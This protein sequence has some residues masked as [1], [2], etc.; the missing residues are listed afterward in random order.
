MILLAPIFVLAALYG[1]LVLRAKPIGNHP[2]FRYDRPLVIAHRGGAGLWPENTLHAFTQAAALGV[3]VLEID[4][5]STRDGQLVVI[6][7]DT[8]ERTAHGTGR[9][10]DLS[11]AELQQLDAGYSWSADQGKTF[12]LRGRGIRIPT[13]AEV[14]S[15]LPH[16]AMII[17]IKAHQPAMVAELG[18]MIRHYHMTSRVL[19]ASF[20]VEI[21]REF[22]RLYPEIATSGASQEVRR[23]YT[24]HL[25]RLSRVYS[26]PMESLDVPEYSDG[27]HIAT[28]RFVNAAHERNLHVHVWTINE[29][30]AMQRLLDYG[31]DGI[32]TDYPD[33]LLR[34]LDSD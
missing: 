2:F 19:V 10:R 28:R 32:T 24:L 33:R 3:D 27:R 31:V 23:F 1:V 34:M 17:E 16:L 9:I 18:R 4:V 25:T 20:D 22:R 15:S 13:L 29:T 14:F 26:P 8:V 6:H 5:Q 30:D 21:M 12:P 11:L 7:D